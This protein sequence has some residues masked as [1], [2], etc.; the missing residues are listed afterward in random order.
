VPSALPDGEPAPARPAPCRPSRCAGTGHAARFGIYVQRAVLARSAAATATSTPTPPSSSAGGAS[1]AAYGRHGPAS[2]PGPGRKGCFGQP[3]RAS[4]RPP[5]RF[6]F[7]GGDA[8]PAC[9]SGDP[10]SRCWRRIRDRFRPPGRGPRVTTEA[11]PDSVTADSLVALAAGWHHP[12]SRS[13]CSQRVPH[14]LRTPR[15]H[16]RPGPGGPGRRLGPAPPGLAVSLDL[17]YGTPGGDTGRLADQPGRGPWPAGLTTSRR[18]RWSWS[19]A[20]NWPRG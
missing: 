1:Q 12:G 14:V 17:I 6:F 11:N 18:T 2:E 10:G 20:R 9:P 19:R 16:P 3:R 4:C 13:G 7:G 15:P 8:D 5:T